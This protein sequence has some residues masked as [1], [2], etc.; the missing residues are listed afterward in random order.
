MSY[1][2]LMALA[3]TALLP[4]AASAQMHEPGNPTVAWTGLLMGLAAVVMVLLL[5]R[6]T[7]RTVSRRRT[8]P[9]AAP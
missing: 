9:P 1:Q 8:P 4:L 2:R 6:F 7:V 5:V 3:A